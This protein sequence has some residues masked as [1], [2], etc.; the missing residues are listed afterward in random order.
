MDNSIGK[1]WTIAVITSA[2]TLWTGE[3]DK[4][5]P[6][7]LTVD[8][9]NTAVL[10]LLS[11]E[12]YAATLEWNKINIDPNIKTIERSVEISDN[13]AMLGICE[14]LN[15]SKETQ[16]LVFNA[17]KDMLEGNQNARQTY[18]TFD[19]WREVSINNLDSWLITLTLTYKDPDSTKPD[20]GKTEISIPNNWENNSKLPVTV[21][22]NWVAITIDDTSIMMNLWLKVTNTDSEKS[23]KNESK[24]TIELTWLS[25]VGKNIIAWIHTQFWPEMLKL[26]ASLGLKVWDKGDLTF[27]WGVVSEEKDIIKWIRDTVKQWELWLDYQHK[28][29]DWFFHYLMMSWKLTKSQGEELS[30][31]Q[32]IVETETLFQFFDHIVWY[33]WWNWYKLTWWLWFKISENGIIEASVVYDE[34]T[35]DRTWTVDKK[36]WYKIAY[37]LKSL[38]GN[39]LAWLNAE[40]TDS[41]DWKEYKISTYFP[42]GERG[43]IS[44]NWT[45]SDYNNEQETTV[46]SIYT[47][48]WGWLTNSQI[49]W[50]MTEDEKKSFENTL[51]M[52]RQAELMQN[53]MGPLHYKWYDLL[54]L[55]ETKEKPKPVVIEEPE[56]PD[57]TPEVDAKDDNFNAKVWETIFLDLWANDSNV[58]SIWEVKWL[59]NWCHAD[60]SGRWVNFKWDSEEICNFSYKGVGKWWN[61]WANVSVNVKND[62]PPNPETPPTI[63]EIW[64]LTWTKWSAFSEDISGKVSQTEWDALIGW[65]IVTGTLPAWITYDSST[66]KFG[67]TP[68]ETGTF[69]LT[70]KVK[71]N[72]WESTKNFSIKIS[73]VANTAPTVSNITSSWDLLNS[74][75]LTNIWLDISDDDLT[76]VTWSLIVIPPSWDWWSFSQSSGTWNTLHWITFNANIWWTTWRTIKATVNDS[77]SGS[78]NE[79]TIYS[80]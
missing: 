58:S 64:E 10:N 31:E 25:D 7:D 1:W 23:G 68:T 48:R 51:R 39:Q 46:W 13:K 2:L 61:D 60:I 77:W 55:K 6:V 19:N 59:T 42:L 67:W 33:D 26:V 14:W 27:L 15:L 75:Q 52:R 37:R 44:L 4:N 18:I 80:N 32:V 50:K 36:M 62:T 28:L 12:A 29:S 74:N 47:Y 49:K 71:D 53:F 69:P 79:Y 78:S 3:K 43:A 73:D 45:Y 5:K 41:L 21:S 57:P 72:D 8:G 76:K 54:V 70:L 22:Q 11:N 16:E 34:F 9:L 56:K 63:S 40:Y 17:I 66:W 30:R 65:Y 24:E 20:L 35:W 38:F